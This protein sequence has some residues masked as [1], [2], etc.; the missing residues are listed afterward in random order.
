MMSLDFIAEAIAETGVQADRL[1][2]AERLNVI[3]KLRERFGIDITTDRP[4]DCVTAPQGKLR[5]DGWKLIPEHIGATEA[6]VW[7]VAAETIW[8]FRQG[9]DLL[10]VLQDCPALEYYVCSPDFGYLL[11]FNH[12][13][14]VIG[15]GTASDWV[16]SLPE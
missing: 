15:W 1:V 2:V 8:K 9:G 11:C 3:S 10:R 5:P 12:H 13:D 7:T 16:A 6:L 4:W 14:Y